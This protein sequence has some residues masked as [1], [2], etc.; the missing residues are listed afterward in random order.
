MIWGLWW[1]IISSKFISS[2]I[3][4]SKFILSKIIWS[5][6]FRRSSF[7]RKS[8]RRNSFRRIYVSS[9]IYFAFKKNLKPSADQKK[10]FTFQASCVRWTCLKK[11]YAQASLES[12]GDPRLLKKYL[13]KHKFSQQNFNI[14]IAVLFRFAIINI[15]F[16]YI[17]FMLLI[18]R[19]N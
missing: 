5:N 8:F 16:K 3:I 13:K 12:M 7:R 17:T 4:S 11:N 9:K 18:I 10:K 14:A 19:K 1:P 2:K 15:I 6:S